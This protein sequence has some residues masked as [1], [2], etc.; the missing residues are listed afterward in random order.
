MPLI[1]TTMEPLWALNSGGMQASTSCLVLSMPFNV[2]IEMASAAF[3]R[4]QTPT[5]LVRNVLF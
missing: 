3:D 2:W 5:S 1:G 4:S